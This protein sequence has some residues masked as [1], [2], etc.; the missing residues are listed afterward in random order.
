MSERSEDTEMTDHTDATNL[1]PSS[2]RS[3]TG[4]RRA[5]VAGAA[6]GVTAVVGVT[7]GAGGLAAAQ[8][9]DPGTGPGPGDGTR[10]EDH[11]HVRGRVV[12]GAGTEAVLELL[13]MTAEELRDAHRDGQTL[14]EIATAK[15][16]STEELVD[17]MLT[18]VEERLADRVDDGFLTQE[19]A[20]ARLAT[21]E[22]RITDRVN[23]DLP[24]RFEGRGPG[25][26]RGERWRS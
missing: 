10:C 6:V 25:H 2:P 21:A 18:G 22:E 8:T 24:E 11:D 7:L 26:G 17:A 13:D 20:D 1:H 5:A 9:D 4:R 12:G 14:A 16:I 15:G 23:G 19:E 3:V